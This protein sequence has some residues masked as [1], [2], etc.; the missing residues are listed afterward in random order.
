MFDLLGVTFLRECKNA[1]IRL[2]TFFRCPNDEIVVKQIDQIKACSCS[3]ECSYDSMDIFRW[4][5]SFLI[6]FSN[7]E[8]SSTHLLSHDVQPNDAAFK[9]H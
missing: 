1:R 9:R 5:F 6:V 2:D 4:V 7:L 8:C 3:D